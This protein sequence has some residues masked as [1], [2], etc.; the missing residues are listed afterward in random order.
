MDGPNCLPNLG[1][2]RRG[3]PPVDRASI[4]LDDLKAF[5]ELGVMDDR[6]D[7]NDL[8]TEPKE[9]PSNVIEHTAPA[10][11]YDFEHRQDI[12]CLARKESNGPMCHSCRP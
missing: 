3:T 8:D 4:E 10:R 12:A 6:F 11:S 9:H 5:D 7:A 2:N 1:A